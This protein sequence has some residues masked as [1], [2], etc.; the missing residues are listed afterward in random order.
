[1]MCW[2]ALDRAGQLAAT[3]DLPTRTQTRWR[4]EAAAIQ[5]FVDER[6]WSEHRRSYTQSAGTD[7]LDAGLLLGCIFGYRPADDARFART[8]DAVREQLSN[9]PFVRR[10]HND[11]GLTGTEGAFVAC[12]FWLVEALA[13]IGRRDEAA[14][15]MERVLALANDVGLYAEEVDLATNEFLGNFPQGLSHLALI[16]AAAA[17]DAPAAS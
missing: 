17:L 14:A 4:N 7:D 10:Y 12:S 5:R 2:V 16:N 9:G 8:I 3:N 6:C 15:L 13:R 1:M 11:D